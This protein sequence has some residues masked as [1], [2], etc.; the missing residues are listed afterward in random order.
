[1]K[2]L[3][4]TADAAALFERFAARHRLSH[5]VKHAP[6]ELCWLF[7]EQSG[8]TLPI[9][10]ALQNGDELSFGVGDFWSYFFPFPEVATEFESIIDSWVTRAA[11]IAVYGGRGRVLEVLK[12]G[13]WRP[14]YS[15][16]RG[17]PMPARPRTFI[18]NAV[19]P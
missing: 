15:A 4:D 3:T 16:N 19:P 8:L 10:L 12:D 1:M 18:Q 9:T 17:F 2:T 11:R 14:A 6:V 13:K 5:S 7:P